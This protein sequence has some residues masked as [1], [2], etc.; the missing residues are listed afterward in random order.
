MKNCHNFVSSSPI[1]MIFGFL[2]SAWLTPQFTQI[3]VLVRR[4]SPKAFPQLNFCKS[5]KEAKKNWKPSIISWVHV[6]LGWFLDFSKALDWHYN[7]SHTIVLVRPLLPK[8]FLSW[9]SINQ[10]FE[11]RLVTPIWA[12]NN[13]TGKAS[14]DSVDYPF[15]P[16]SVERWT[17]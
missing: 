12:I 6:R 16:L 17:N 7:S 2:E 15:W 9:I 13:I 11:K 3:I 10:Y 8:A 14:S 5:E 4:L 1:G